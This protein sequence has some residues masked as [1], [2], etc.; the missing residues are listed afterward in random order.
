MFD[1]GNVLIPTRTQPDFALQ[2]ASMINAV[3]ASAAS[4]QTVTTGYVTEFLQSDVVVQYELG[5]LTTSEFTKK[6]SQHFNVANSLL[7]AKAY[8]TLLLQPYAWVTAVLIRAR[9]YGNVYVLSNTSALHRVK[10]DMLLDSIGA[11]DNLI[12]KKILSYEIGMRKPDI[13]MFKHMLSVVKCYPEEIVYI[14]DLQ[15][16]VNAAKGLGIEA[17][18]LENPEDLLDLVLQVVR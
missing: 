10:A 16:C 15:A 14:D 6:M 8:N 17:Y 9:L 13:E 4:N 12:E 3:T 18:R 2:I 11:T 7:M 5:N 1:L